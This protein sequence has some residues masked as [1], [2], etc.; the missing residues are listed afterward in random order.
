LI[1]VRLVSNTSEGKRSL[2]SFGSGILPG[3][4]EGIARACMHERL[5]GPMVGLLLFAGSWGKWSARD[6]SVFRWKICTVIT[7]VSNRPLNIS[8]KI[9]SHQLWR[10]KLR[11]LDFLPL[12]EA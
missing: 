10:E 7:T 11:I 2:G 8:V 4:L 9:Y 5:V 3:I 1:L 6:R 12:K